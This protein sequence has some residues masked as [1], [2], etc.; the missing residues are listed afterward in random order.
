MMAR[1]TILAGLAGGMA[2]L[3]AGCGLLGGNKYRFRMTVE[4]DTPQGLRSGS[5][6]YEV[7][8]WNSPK[9]LPDERAR[10]WRVR[11]EALTISLPDGPVFVLL[12]TGNRYRSDFAAMS[13]GTLDPDFDND[14][15]ESAGRISGSWSTRRGEVP[16]ADW[17]LMVRFR[18]LGDPTSVERVDP[19][20]IG[21]KRIVLETTSDEVTTGIEK[22]LGWLRDA[23]LMKASWAQLPYEARSTIIHLTSNVGEGL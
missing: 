6:V 12:K 16:R 5:S 17:P 3:L 7:S 14:V 9:I 20:A 8:A 19:E 23:D 10:D 13:M 1:R 22:R 11:G 15:V 18:D 21:V 2:A 4:V